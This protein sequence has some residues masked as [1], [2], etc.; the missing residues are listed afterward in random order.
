MIFSYKKGKNAVEGI[1]TRIYQYGNDW[2][3]IIHQLISGIP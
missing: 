1:W 3:M 2:R